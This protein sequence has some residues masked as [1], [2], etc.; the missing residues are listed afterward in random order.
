M[1]IAKFF[2]R[3]GIKFVAAKR[4]GVCAPLMTRFTNYELPT[5]NQ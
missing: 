4:A 5:T 2:I 1:F 3:R